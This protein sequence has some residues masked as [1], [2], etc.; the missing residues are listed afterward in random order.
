[1]CI[2]T[3]C[4]RGDNS[5]NIGDTVKINPNKT[6][7]ENVW[8]CMIGN[9]GCFLSRLLKKGKKLEPPSQA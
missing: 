5:A 7:N 1:M 6:I 8:I 4:S 9:N 3:N 2:V